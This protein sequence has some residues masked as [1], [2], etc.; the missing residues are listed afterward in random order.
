MISRDE[1]CY[2]TEFIVLSAITLRAAVSVTA[3][4]FFA[5]GEHCNVQNRQKESAQSHGY[6]DGY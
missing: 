5:E 3:R 6:N 2:Y 1:Q 4:A